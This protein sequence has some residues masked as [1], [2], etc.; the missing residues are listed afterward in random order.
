[1]NPAWLHGSAR[2]ERSVLSSGVY[3]EANA[4]VEESVLMP[5]VHVGRG[6]RVRHAIVEEGMKI[7]DGVSIGLDPANDR[8]HYMLTESGI[9]VIS[10]LQS[11]SKAAVYF[12]TKAL[13][14]T[15]R[16]PGPVKT[17][18]F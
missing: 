4:V 18:A 12:Q 15:N 14:G 3:V 6:A 17:A 9:V 8:K 13:R 10:P 5:A 16:T 7:P 2:I 11:S 1:M